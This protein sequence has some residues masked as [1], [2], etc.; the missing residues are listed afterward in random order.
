MIHSHCGA[1]YADC[2]L[3][4]DETKYMGIKHVP[5]AR[6]RTRTRARTPT[7]TRTRTRIAGH[8]HPRPTSDQ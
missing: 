6:A 1:D 3:C 7:R 5:C 8:R 2:E 4:D